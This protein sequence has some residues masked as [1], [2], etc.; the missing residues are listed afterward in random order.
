MF[1]FAGQFDSCGRT[2]WPIKP[3][4][5][6]CVPSSSPET[7]LLLTESFHLIDEWKDFNFFSLLKVSVEVRRA[8]NWIWMEIK[9]VIWAWRPERTFSALR[10]T[11]K[12]KEV[13]NDYSSN[14]ERLKI[15]ENRFKASK[16]LSLPRIKSSVFQQTHFLTGPN[17]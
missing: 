14:L 15:F 4:K 7:R 2:H 1:L 16:P 11:K 5:K 12:K 8:R 10:W 6:I 13:G 3:L 9:F 17:N